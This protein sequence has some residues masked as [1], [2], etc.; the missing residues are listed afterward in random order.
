MHAE[1]YAQRLLN[2]FRGVVNTI[3][4]GA[5]EAVTTDGAHWDIYVSNEELA[6]G[7]DDGTRLQ[8]SDIRYGSW[9]REAGLKRGP[10]YPSDDFRRMEEM[11][12]I[13]YQHLTRNHDRVPFPFGDRFELWLLDADAMPLALL[14]SALSERELDQEYSVAWGAGFM[15]RDRFHSAAMQSICRSSGAPVNAGDYLTAH[16]NARAGPA[17]AAQWFLRESDGT[18]LGLHGIGMNEKLTGWRLSAADFPQFFLSAH[19]QDEAHRRLIEDYLAWQS[20]WLLLLSGLD[21]DTRRSLEKQA[22]MR[23]Q[24]VLKQH[25][26]YPACADAEEIRAALVEAVLVGN[27]DEAQKNPATLSTFYIELNPAGGNY[28]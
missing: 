10:I 1:Y 7:V 21:T 2:P 28:T 3:R 24:E 26:L 14:D 20:P 16:I 19:G 18:G 25:R 11:G 5:A 8:I 12:A 27:Q 13:V 6:R 22:R 4:Y 17:P 23:C 9:S 15:A